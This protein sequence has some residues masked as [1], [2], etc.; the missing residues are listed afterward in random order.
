MNKTKIDGDSIIQYEF[1]SNDGKIDVFIETDEE[2]DTFYILKDF[3]D[4]LYIITD[5]NIFK[6]M[7]EYY[8]IKIM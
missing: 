6:N 5:F 2:G 7:L 3:N 8:K 4:K 1:E